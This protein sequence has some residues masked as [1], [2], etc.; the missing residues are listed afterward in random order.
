MTSRDTA[1]ESTATPDRV[2]VVGGGRWA[3]VILDVLCDLLPMHVALT[4]HTRAGGAVREWQAEHPRRNRIELGESLPATDVGAVIV[5]NAARDHVAAAESALRA[6]SFVL[7]EK[8]LT[9][10]F[11]AT[12]DL[13]NR[14]AA[15]GGRLA[16]AHVFLFA[17]YVENFAAAMAVAGRPEAVEFIWTDPALEERHGEVKRYDA[18]LT[19]FADWLPHVL[20]IL[21]TFLPAWPASA[22]LSAVRGG[23]AEVDLELEGTGVPCQV[24]LARNAAGRRRILQVRAAGEMCELDFSTEPGTLSVGG[25]ARDADPEWAT[26]RRPLARMLAAFLAWSAGATRDP[27]LDPAAGLR[28]SQLVEELDAAYRISSG[29]W[30]AARLATAAPIDAAAAYALAEL[31]QREGRWTA[32]EATAEIAALSGRCVGPAALTGNSPAAQFLR[33]FVSDNLPA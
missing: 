9:P 28:C 24:H 23:G 12:R 31:L 30:L 7:V 2:A 16:A 22:R 29:R 25:T 4:V 26:C 13:L 33:A 19:V 10:R 5:A 18:G 15:T 3:R 1:V 17:R 27:R 20:P 6:G 8:P 32:A 11:A 21:A 14:A